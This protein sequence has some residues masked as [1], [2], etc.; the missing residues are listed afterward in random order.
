MNRTNKILA[1][2][3]LAAPAAVQAQMKGTRVDTAGPQ[4]AAGAAKRFLLGSNWRETWSAPITVPVLDLNMFGGGLT[5]LQQGGN[6]T[7]T[8]RFKGGDNRLYTFRS[9]NK[10]PPRRLHDDLQ[11]TFASQLIQ[12]Q[13]SGLHPT[14]HL[15]VAGLQ[16]RL[17]LLHAPGQLVI[18]PDDPRL[19]EFRKQ[20]AGMLGQIEEFPEDEEEGTAGFAGAKKIKGTYKLFEDLEESSTNAVHVREYLTA[21]L[22]DF[23]VGDTD[24]G[25]DQWRWARFDQGDLRVWRPIP[26]DRDY[27]FILAN[28]VVPTLVG[29]V[30]PKLV[31]F[32]EQFSGLSS[33]TFMT[34]DFDRSHLVAL[35]WPTWEATISRIQN[36]LSDVAIENAV[37]R[38]PA[39]HQTHS[40]EAMIEGLRARRDGLPA[41]ARKFYLMINR[42]ADIHASDEAER[43]DLLRNADGSVDVTIIRNADATANDGDNGNRNI[44]IFQRRFVPGE[45]EEIR[46]FMH[47]GNDRVTIRGGGR[48]GIRVRVMAGAGN[49]EL[50]DY[51]AVTAG[52]DH[53][54]FYDSHGTNRFQTA[55]G[56]KVI[57]KPYVMVQPQDVEPDEDQAEAPAESKPREVLEERRG[58]F[59]DQWS[60]PGKNFIEARTQPGLTRDWGSRRAWLPAP[61][62]RDGAG[63]VVG[64]GMKYTRFGFR[65]VPH[66]WQINLRGFYALGSGGFAGETVFDYNPEN[67]RLNYSLLVR[68]SQFEANRFYGFG[69]DTD[70]IGRDLSLVMRDE[71]LVKPAVNWLLGRTELSVGPLLRY[72]NNRPENNSPFEDVQPLGGTSFT[73]LGAQVAA[74]YSNADHY[75]HPRRGA[76]LSAGASAYPAVWDVPE[77]FGEVHA[78]AAVYLPIGWPTLALRAGGKRVFGTFPV[79]ESAFVGGRTTLRGFR[80]NRFAGD[81]AVHGAAELRVPLARLEL[82]T[83]GQLGALGFVDAGRVWFDGD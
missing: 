30:F 15:A 49:D 18:L 31:K 53:T 17:G 81:A 78:D 43:A 8:L 72:V 80:W 16:A 46:V 40:A 12:D 9:T 65:H 29:M 48:S 68:G 83:R 25:A 45:T 10:Y 24:R 13:V 52:G 69:N 4:Y 58:R 73:Q 37:R 74:E 26:R 1:V 22:I 6:Q 67:S 64:A 3:L 44:T 57:V 51:G 76:V 82:I 7:R 5:P 28:G 11:D 33:Y 34:R 50:L 42:E 55:R 32:G 70:L 23:M 27:A 38:L 61:D 2:L 60:D 54:F 59:Q 66:Q 75:S 62:Y 39:G 19:G 79:H 71:L 56:T 14:G 20:F 77:A 35:P 21:R 36:E 41:M 47:G 63:V